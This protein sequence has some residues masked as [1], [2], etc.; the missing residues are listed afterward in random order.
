MEIERASS[1][2]SPVHKDNVSKGKSHSCTA[3]DV[4]FYSLDLEVQIGDGTSI[5][6][7]SS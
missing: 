2:W 1:S 6:L 5:K 7:F 3:N 4:S